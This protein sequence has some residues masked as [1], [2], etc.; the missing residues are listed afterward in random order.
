MLPFD[1]SK[2]DITQAMDMVKKLQSRMAEM[3]TGL[4]RIELSTEVGGG[5]VAVRANA[6]GEVIAI[7]ISAEALEL[8]DAA[9]LSSLV[10]SGV[11][12]ALALARE[13]REQER[14]KASLDMLPGWMA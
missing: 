12:Q 1:L 11:N 13:R 2:I 6:A 14:Q 9:V 5:M 4:R 7:D 8:K 10:L 3:E